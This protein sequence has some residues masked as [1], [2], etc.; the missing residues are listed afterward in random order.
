MYM[1]GKYYKQITGKDAKMNTA[2]C[3]LKKGRVID[4]KIGNKIMSNDG[5]AGVSFLQTTYN[6]FSEMMKVWIRL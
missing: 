3:I 6:S 1:T 4:D 2:F 5:V